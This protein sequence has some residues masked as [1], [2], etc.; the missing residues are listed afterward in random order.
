M[1]SKS[2]HCLNFFISGG[3]TCRVKS[4]L[5][6]PTK[7]TSDQLSKLVDV[8]S[9]TV[10]LVKLDVVSPVKL[11]VTSQQWPLTGV[12]PGI[13]KLKRKLGP[14]MTVQNTK[15]SSHEKYP[16][17]EALTHGLSPGGSDLTMKLKLSHG[18]SPT[19]VS[20]NTLR[21]EK[22]IVSSP[23]KIKIP[24]VN[25]HSPSRESNCHPVGE[26]VEPKVGLKLVIN[27]ERFNT[28]ENEGESHHRRH[29]HK[30]K[31]HK[32]RR[33]HH[34]HDRE[35]REHRHSRKRAHSPGHSRS[36]GDHS[37]SAKHSRPDLSAERY[38]QARQTIGELMKATQKQMEQQGQSAFNARTQQVLSSNV[39][40]PAFCSDSPEHGI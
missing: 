30:H 1:T 26:C 40:A 24:H 21:S 23:L 6:S 22:D 33:S 18:A 5:K 36:H 4:D 8:T 11:D 2:L 25:N 9:P 37:S 3:Y 12:A 34:H 14:N 31:H 20:S 17:H 16:V 39:Q 38:D 10:D 32:K 27:K 13:H 35:D 7:V 29:K 28:S 15:L 19:I